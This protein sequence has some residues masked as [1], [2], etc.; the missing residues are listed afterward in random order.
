MD[1][2]SSSGRKPKTKK[3]IEL[4]GG[5]NNE[6]AAVEITLLSM[7]VKENNACEDG[8]ETQTKLKMTLLY[9]KGE[10]NPYKRRQITTIIQIPV[11]KTYKS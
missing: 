3:N 8:K 9:Q 6:T 10:D 5:H 2:Q 7:E 11:S 1:T 4:A